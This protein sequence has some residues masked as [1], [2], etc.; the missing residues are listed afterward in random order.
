MGEARR[1]E[2][3]ERGETEIDDGSRRDG[4]IIEGVKTKTR[5]TDRH[6]REKDGKGGT[7][8]QPDGDTRGADA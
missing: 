2:R 4:I 1:A 7:L 5:E 6:E 8:V 3:R